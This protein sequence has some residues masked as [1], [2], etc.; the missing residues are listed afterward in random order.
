MADLGRPFR[1]AEATNSQ[2]RPHFMCVCVKGVDAGLGY[3]RRKQPV[4]QRHVIEDGQK[5]IEMITRTR[6]RCRI[7]STNVVC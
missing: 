6:T 3:S 2:S 5:R 1:S 4:E 7:V